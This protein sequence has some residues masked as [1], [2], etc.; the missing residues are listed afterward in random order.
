MVKGLGKILGIGLLSLLLLLPGLSAWADK[1]VEPLVFDAGGGAIAVLSFYET[2]PA[3]QADA[4]KSFYKSTKSFYKT[5]P[6]FLGW[7]LFSSTD[8]TRVAELSQWRDQD[9]YDAFQISLASDGDGEDY[10]KYYEAYASAKGGKGKGK[11]KESV[12]LGDPVLTVSFA[13]DQVVS[14]PGMVSAIPGNMA[15]VQISDITTDADHPIN[16]VAAAHAALAD[17][18]QFYPAPRTA[19]LLTG[20]EVNH[21]ALLAN[22]GSVAE[23]SDLDQVPR[24]TLPDDIALAIDDVPDDPEDVS[25]TAD[26]HL[27]QTV[28][29]ITPKAETSSKE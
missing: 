2:E 24:I 19:I 21:I 6:G 1:V 16:L 26:T 8:G 7:A 15:L 25:F 4:V 22:W 28:K 12:E 18:S 3:T 11:A 5:I 27:Y 20:L 23:F 17:L 9:S 14:P 10:T 29:V 13:V